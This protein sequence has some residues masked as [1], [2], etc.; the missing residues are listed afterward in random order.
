[1]MIPELKEVLR[2]AGINLNGIYFG[3]GLPTL[4]DVWA[5]GESRGLWEVYY[6]ER[7]NEKRTYLCERRRRMLVFPEYAP[8][9]QKVSADIKSGHYEM[10]HAVLAFVSALMVFPAI[11]SGPRPNVAIEA[12]SDLKGLCEADLKSG[13]YAMC[14]A[15][16]SAVLEVMENNSIYGVKACILRW[17]MSTKRLTCPPN[18]S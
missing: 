3:A 10:R 5:I 11:A 2:T 9:K 12:G 8:G 13:E 18:G 16:N 4:S 7:V 6:F 15:F 14:Y 1:M 17:L